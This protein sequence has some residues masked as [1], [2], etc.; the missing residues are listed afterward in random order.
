MAGQ[1]PALLLDRSNKPGTKSLWP[2]TLAVPLPRHAQTQEQQMCQSPQ[3]MAA[4]HLFPLMA[5][6]TSHPCFS[7]TSEI[8]CHCSCQGTG[9]AIIAEDAVCT[10]MSLTQGMFKGQPRQ[11]SQGSSKGALGDTRPLYGGE[12]KRLPLCKSWEESTAATRNWE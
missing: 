12:N 10:A 1:I 2:R 9:P 8:I 5:P 4:R 7:G 6:Q 11:T 3:Q